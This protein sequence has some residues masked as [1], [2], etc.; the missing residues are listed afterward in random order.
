MILGL[1]RVA[2]KSRP[3]KN[4]DGSRCLNPS[5]PYPNNI[6]DI[7]TL[8][9]GI[10][11]SYSID[12]TRNDD[13]GDP[14]TERKNFIGMKYFHPECFNQYAFW[15][16]NNKEKFQKKRGRKP[17]PITDESRVA[18]NRLVGYIDRDKEQ[19][20]KAY[21]ADSKYRVILAWNNLIKHNLEVN[22]LAPYKMNL[23]NPPGLMPH[24][25]SFLLDKDP[26]ELRGQ[27]PD[28]SIE[29]LAQLTI[30]KINGAEIEAQK[31]T[32]E[33]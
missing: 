5:C 27:E 11:S 32:D 10:K 25:L 2:M 13:K 33:S 14:S 1:V 23:S 22:K 15:M 19:L 16:Y 4:R 18:R 7:G 26:R 12:V 9:L 28:A 3:T 8:Y 20:L 30:D 29:E 31:N 24:I 6:I 21:L 17:L